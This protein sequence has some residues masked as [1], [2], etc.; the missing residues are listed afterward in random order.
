MCST[1]EGSFV[2]LRTKDE[3]L[4][5]TKGGGGSETKINKLVTVQRGEGKESKLAGFTKKKVEGVP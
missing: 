5:K 2:F 1:V 4:S 3:G